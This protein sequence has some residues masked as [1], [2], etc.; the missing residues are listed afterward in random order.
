MEEMNKVDILIV[1]K[2]GTL[3]EGKPSLNSYKSFGSLSD[4]E[5]LKLA[6]SVDADSEHPLADAIVEGAK[7]EKLEL[8]QLDKFESLTGKGVK[9]MYKGKPIGLGNHR[10]MEDFGAKLNDEQKQMAQEWQLTG[11]TVMY[12]ILGKKVCLLYTSR[13]RQRQRRKGR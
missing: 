8:L 7:A 4:K 6:A 5:I 11:Q 3:T 13:W 12:L 9:A 2:T 1:D 10:L